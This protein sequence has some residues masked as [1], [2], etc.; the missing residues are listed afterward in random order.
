[1]LSRPRKGFIGPIGD[2]LPSIL[3][4]VLALGLFFAGIA[5]SF[6]VY[7]QKMDNLKTMKGAIEITR[8]ITQEVIISDPHCT[9]TA[10]DIAASYGLGCEASFDLNVCQE[11]SYVFTY[12]VATPPSVPSSSG[13][14]V[15]SGEINTFTLSTQLKICM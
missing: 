13:R 15:S 9:P 3:G 7:N 11:K 10:Q 5:Y 1:M 12:L 2:D 4:I 14:A 6:D 8:V